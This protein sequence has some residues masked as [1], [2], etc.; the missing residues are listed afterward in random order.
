MLEAVPGAGAAP[1][2]DAEAAPGV[3]GVA[4]PGVLG[5]AFVG[6]GMGNLISVGLKQSISSPVLNSP[7]AFSPNTYMRRSGFEGSAVA[8]CPQPA[9]A[10]GVE[11]VCAPDAALLEAFILP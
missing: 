5:P 3:A 2:A 1:E 11:G 8:F 7:C 6:R 9:L 10:L 4:E